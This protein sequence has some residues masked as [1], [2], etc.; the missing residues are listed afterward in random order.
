[1]RNAATI[2]AIWDGGCGGVRCLPSVRLW[3]GI[4]GVVGTPNFGR[5]G[6]GEAIKICGLRAGDIVEAPV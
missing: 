2:F 4:A 5:A 1:M 3:L 6:P